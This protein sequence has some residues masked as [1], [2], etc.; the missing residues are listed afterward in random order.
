MKSKR[1]LRRDYKER[2]KT[3]GVFQVK[4]VG[5]GKVLLASSLNLEGAVNR[6][7]FTL[8]TG[9]HPNKD[10]QRDWDEDGPDKFVFEILEVVEVEDDPGLDLDEELKLLEQIWIEKLEPFGEHGY[11]KGSSIRQV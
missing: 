11:N 3:G 1:D 6:N 9:G 4:H 7:K 8:T 10:L 5:N 2:R